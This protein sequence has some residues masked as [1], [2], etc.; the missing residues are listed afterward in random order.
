MD[1]EQY[2]LKVGKIAVFKS[3]LL[4]TNKNSQSSQDQTLMQKIGKWSTEVSAQGC[5]NTA[6]RARHLMCGNWETGLGS[7]T[8]L[9][10]PLV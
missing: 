2:V 10:I 3:Q 9:P 6:E 7:L 1:R 8:R 4:K 5:E